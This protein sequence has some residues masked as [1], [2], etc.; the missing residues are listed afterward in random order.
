MI[1]AHEAKLL[2]VST[3][4]GRPQGGLKKEKYNNGNLSTYFGHP[5]GGTQQKEYVKIYY[6]NHTF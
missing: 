6:F 1:Y 5:Q 3:F 2:H 4:F